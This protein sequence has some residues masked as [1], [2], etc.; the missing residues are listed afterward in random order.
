MPKMRVNIGTPEL[1]NW[2][3]LDANNLESVDRIHFRINANKLEYS[4]DGIVWNVI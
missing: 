3:I 4:T 2:I 1:P